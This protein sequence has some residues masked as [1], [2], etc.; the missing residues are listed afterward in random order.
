VALTLGREDRLPA[1]RPSRFTAGDRAVAYPRR[2]LFGRHIVDTYFLT[3]AYDVTHRALAGHGLKEVARH[4]GL[5]RP[6]RTYIPGAEIARIAREDPAR[7]ERYVRD[8]A[9]ET[10]ALSDLLSPVYFAQAQWLPFGYQD[11][12]LRGNAAKID[13]LMQRAYL[14]E[15]RALPRPGSARPFAGGYT[16]IFLT[17][18]ARPVR[19]ADIRSLYPSLMLRERI[20]PAADDGGVFLSLLDALRTRR[21]RAKDEMRRAADPAARLFWDAQQSTAKVLINSFY[22]YLGFEMARWNDFDAA[23]RVTAA[24]RALLRALVE[25]IRALGAAPVEIDTD[26]IYYI[27]PA[28]GDDAAFESA[29]RAGLPEGIEIE[30]DGRYEAMFS[31]KMKNYALLDEKGEIVLRGAAL[32]SRGLEPFQREFLRDWLELRLRGRDEERRALR[33]TYRRRIAKRTEPIAWLARTETLQDAPATYAA[34]RTAGGRGR[35]AAYELAQAAD[36][37]YRAGDRVSYY[38]A[39]DRKNV[40]VYAAARLVSDWNPERRDENVA[41]YLS[42]LDELADRLEAVETPPAAPSGQ[43]ELSLG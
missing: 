19:H 39:G 41:Y 33:E 12:C 7:L 3:L 1:A 26:G 17:G 18:L 13:A 4:F 5:A 9:R 24:G 30:F 43:G 37:E 10:R 38:V 36:R 25:K 31:Y 21:L 34:R 32:K 15:R 42:K 35:N 2:D 28:D 22:G 8:D 14:A 23:E 11:V 27:P 16:D 29:V 6:D 40:A 20:G